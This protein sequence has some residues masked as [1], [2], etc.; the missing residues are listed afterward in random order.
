MVD[1]SKH[2]VY[3]ESRKMEMVPYSV[4][5]QAITEMLNNYNE[6]TEDFEK[7]IKDWTDSVYNFVGLDD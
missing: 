3:V 1:L 7:A 5:M 2:K 4:A 6:L